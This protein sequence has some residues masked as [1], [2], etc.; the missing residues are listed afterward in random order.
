MNDALDSIRQHLRER[1]GAGHDLTPAEMGALADDLA[2]HPALWREFV[3]H[4]DDERVYTQ[5]FRDHNLDVWLICWSGDQDTGLHDHDLSSGAVRV[6]EG[7]LA[8]DRLVFGRGF[9]T[10][11]YGPGETF[12][13]DATRIHDVRHAGD[14]PTVSLHLYSPPIWR[15]GYYEV[16]E[17]GRVARRSASYAEELQAS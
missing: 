3:R 17:D 11:T 9:D 16:D 1:L 15:M 4:S 14:A 2:A 7:E 6:V 8:E 10:T 12:C 13:F 5:I